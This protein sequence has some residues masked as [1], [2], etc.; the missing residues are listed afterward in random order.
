MMDKYDV[1][2]ILQTYAEKISKCA[3]QD[4]LKD[5]IKELKADLDLRKIKL[6]K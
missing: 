1:A 5:L 2:G 6:E 3:R 4:K